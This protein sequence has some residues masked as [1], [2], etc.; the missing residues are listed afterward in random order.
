VF[1]PPG[2]ECWWWPSVVSPGSR[3]LSDGGSPRPVGGRWPVGES[4][5]GGLVCVRECPG[6]AVCDSA[7]LVFGCGAAIM[8][9]SP[10]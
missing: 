10:G 3:S 8:V 5:L 2:G 6:V 7:P 4:A 9:W 1:L